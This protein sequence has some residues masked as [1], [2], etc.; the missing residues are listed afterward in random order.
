MSGEPGL[1][2]ASVS[3]NPNRL[4]SPIKPFCPVGEKA[5][6]YPHRYHWN[7]MT[8]PAPMHAHIIDRA[9]FR[10]ARPE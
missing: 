7:V 1:G 4:R 6:E 8:D 3:I 10:R 9:D 2:F 5:K